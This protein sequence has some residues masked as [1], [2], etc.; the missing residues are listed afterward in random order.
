LRGQRRAQVGVDALPLVGK[1]RQ[2]VVDRDL[3]D[4]GLARQG[5]LRRGF[6]GA[7]IEAGTD[8]GAEQQAGAEQAA[9]RWQMG[10]HGRASQL[11]ARRD[12]R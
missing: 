8:T 5:R 4:A 11:S 10:R 7:G 1:R 3:E 12:S 2:L 6:G 9:A